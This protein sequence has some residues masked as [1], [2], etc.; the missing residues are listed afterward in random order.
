MAKFDI[1]AVINYILSKTGRDKLIYIGYSMG[2]SM[3]FAS[4]AT[5]P[6]LNSKIDVMVGM[7]PAV[8]LAHLSSP[9]IKKIAPFVKHIE[10]DRIQL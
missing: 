1:P 7:A 10:V 5:H 8:S 2:C 4:L 6:E 9:V 3:F